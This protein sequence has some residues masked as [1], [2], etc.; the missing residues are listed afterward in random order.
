[1]DITVL[2]CD[3]RDFTAASEKLNP[4]EVV[5]L[6]N[7]YYS[8]MTKVI[9]N[10]DGVV[11]QFVGDEIFA[12]FGAP[13]SITNSQ[14]KAVYCAYDMLNELDEINIE[15]KKSI[16]VEI[17][18]G[19]GINHGPAVVGN[20]GSDDRIVYSVTGDTVNTGKRIEALTKSC[21]NTILISE[22]VHQHTTQLIETKAWEPI[23][24]KGKSEKVLVYEVL[25]LST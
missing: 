15:L 6:L 20:L 14:E 5:F 22:S 13:L 17:K 24:V 2:F 18:V 4:T 8:K 11:H 19:I 23:S 16:S 10:N 12:T 9:R 25:S 21:P 3:I 1:M 7:V